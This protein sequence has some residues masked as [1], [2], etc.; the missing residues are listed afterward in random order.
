MRASRVLPSRWHV[1][2]CKGG[3]R[4][5]YFFLLIC[6]LFGPSFGAERKQIVSVGKDI[7]FCLDLSESMNAAD[8]AP[9]RLERVKFEMKKIITAFRGDRAGVVIFSGDA[10]VQCPLT[11]DTSALHLFTQSISTSLVPNTGTEFL[12]PLRMVLEKIQ[13][14][15]RKNGKGGRTCRCF[16]K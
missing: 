1:L 6:A 5:F 15:C 11:Y 8:V 14:R 4:A 3:L 10:F 9:T 7:F 16:D 13:G 12:P 2:L